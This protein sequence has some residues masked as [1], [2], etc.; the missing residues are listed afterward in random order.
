MPGI[1]KTSVAN[2]ICSRLHAEK[3]LG[4]SF[5]CR[6][7]DPNLSNPDYV[8]PT[9]TCRLA[10]TWGPF[11]K[12]VAAELSKDPHI[13][14]KSTEGELLSKLLKSL[15]NQPPHPLVL[16]IDALDECG[17][18]KARGSILRRIFD[19][20][21]SVPWLKF[22]LTSRPEGDIDAFFQ[23][24]DRFGRYLLEDLSKDDKSQEDIRYFTQKR[25][26]SIAVAKHLGKVWPQE[27]MVNKIVIQARGLFIF[28]ETLWRLV[29]DEPEAP[30]Y[31]SQI[32]D[33]S[34]GDALGDLY[35]LYSSILE[36]RIPREGTEFKS[37]MGT[38]LVVATY[39]P[40]CAETIAMLTG[41]EA[42]VVKTWVDSM[43]SLLY[44]DE[45]RNGGIRVRHLSIIDFLTS[46]NCPEEFRVDIQQA[47]EE[48][49]LACL[50]A[51]ISS[52]KFNMC[53][54]ESSLLLNEEVE[55][56]KKRVAEKISDELQYS[57]MHW[58]SHLAHCPYPAHSDIM[59]RLDRFFEDMG[60][61]Y[62]IEA[63]SL[64]GEIPIGIPMLR[65]V[66]QWAKGPRIPV[67]EDI[68][69]VLRF[70]LAFRVPITASTPHIYISGLGF[71]PRES[72]LWKKAGG[73]FEKMIRVEKGRMER[74]PARP[75]MWTGHTSSVCS[76]AY[77]R[78]GR[79]VA[80]GSLDNTIR[81]WDTESGAPVG[82]PLK[83]HTNSVWS[84][85][86]SPDG[87]YV[88]SGSSDNTIRIWDTESGA[89]V[90][91]P[92]KGRTNFVY[93]VAYSRDGRYVVS[94]SDDKTIRIWDTESGA[95]VG[96][97]LKGHTDSVWSVAYSR[98]GRYVASGSLDNTIR[99]WDTESGAPVGEPLKGHTNSVWSV[100]YSPDGRY[101]VS[102]SS[103][104]TIRIWDTESGAPVGEPLKGHTDSVWSVAYSPDGR[105][106]ASG[107]L[108]NTIRIWDTESGAPVGE[109]LKG[110]TN[111]VWSVAYSPDGLHVVSGSIDKS[112]QIWNT[113]ILQDSYAVSLYPD[114]NGWVKH[115]NGGLLFW[116]PEDCCNG[117]TCPA[118]LTFPTEGLCRT[119]R[120][121]LSD[122]SFGL[123]WEQIFKG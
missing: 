64:I 70:L 105:Y 69:D 12:V 114:D 20:T 31:L 21:S 14:P 7:D 53:G 72:V 57:C 94:G 101:V 95:P 33:E 49:A 84:V 22:L 107:S 67:L 78:D 80:S 30:K 76:V 66:V 52:L 60:P 119:V 41:R 23:H 11:R 113:Q 110:H 29:K 32:L 38:I 5:F 108:D 71:T 18:D 4:G 99:I 83:G 37:T 77:S 81:I 61:L 36:S 56:M 58:S 28:V 47:H 45:R 75:I 46:S 42:Y 86:Y 79:Y 115:P 13:T 82:E 3:I 16:V 24:P 10:E 62:W 109:P 1:G 8:L 120:V 91:E 51:M 100:A 88:V 112:V 122:F 6:R 92:L 17:D 39:R 102:G 93:S 40:L 35:R 54:L 97:P 117:L 26:S 59:R 27:D 87:R 96:E 118:V 55:D 111:S 44:R 74:W 104:N 2:S 63:L 85:A 116:V 123:S 50:D 65:Q 9:L 89:P 25:L 98:D 103:D 43:N 73:G 34:S 90:G 19:A 68:D 106:V 48:V 15:K 121:D